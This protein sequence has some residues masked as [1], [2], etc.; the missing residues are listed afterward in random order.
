VKRVVVHGIPA[1]GGISQARERKRKDN[2]KRILGKVASPG[3]LLGVIAIVIALT[4]TAFAALKLGQ[5]N[6]SSRDRLAGTGVIQYA[7]ASFTTPASVAEFNTIHRYEVKCELSKKAT[8]GGFKWTS[9]PPNEGDYQL[10][11]AYPTGQGFVVRLQVNPGTPPTDTSSA[12]NKPLAVYA[13]CVK[14]RK[15]RGTPPA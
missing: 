5:F 6:A 9:T 13:N 8:S 14:S 3:T 4:G 12:E 2:M 10:V 7:S 15:Q 11:D 1:I